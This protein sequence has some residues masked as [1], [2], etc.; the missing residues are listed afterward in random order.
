MA[1]R[2]KD[3]VHRFLM[4][5]QTGKCTGTAPISYRKIAAVIGIV[6]AVILVVVLCM[7]I[8]GAIASSQ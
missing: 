1:Y 8:V 6:L 5:G 2:Y 7:G 3:Q 4:N